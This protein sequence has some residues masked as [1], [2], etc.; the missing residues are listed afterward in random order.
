VETEEGTEIELGG[1]EKLDFSDVNL[2]NVSIKS[3]IRLRNGDN[4]RFGEGRCLE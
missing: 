3:C 1:L 4:P 2:E